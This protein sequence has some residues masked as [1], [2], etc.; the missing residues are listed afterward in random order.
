MAFIKRM[1]IVELFCTT[2]ERVYERLEK[3]GLI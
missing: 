2:I 1:T 3:D